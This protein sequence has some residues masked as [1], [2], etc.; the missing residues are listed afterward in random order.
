MR[1]Y[2][3]LTLAC[4]SILFV[5]CKNELGGSYGYEELFNGENTNALAPIETSS[6]G[7]D[8]EGFFH[9][10]EFPSLGWTLL[11]DLYPNK[12]REFQGDARTD[13][14]LAVIVN[15]ASVLKYID[16]PNYGR[17][18]RWPEID[19]NKY[20]LVVG[21][22]WYVGG[23][24]L[25]LRDQRVVVSEG[26]TTVYLRFVKKSDDYGE[27]ADIK[28]LYFGAVYSKLP[29]GPVEIIKWI[30]QSEEVNR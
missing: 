8:W 17:V 25:S 9:S 22:Y 27:S 24:F 29:D 30:D 15:E 19:F 14:D 1:T 18:F 12:A 2:L 21:Q 4:V 16:A 11:N 7:I 13:E 26:K 10:L 28:M 6:S 3:L 20:S 23:S 5:G